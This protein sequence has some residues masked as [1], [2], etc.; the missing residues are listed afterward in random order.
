VAEPAANVAQQ[1]GLNRAILICGWGLAEGML[2]YKCARN[3]SDLLKIPPHGSSRTCS[4]CDDRDL[5]NGVTRDRFHG[6][7][8]R[9]EQVADWNAALA[10][11]GQ[12]EDAG[13]ASLA[14][15]WR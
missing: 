1:S 12:L 15:G 13:L 8:C 11:T 4:E 6:I 2:A 10:I 5:L 9:H 14:R 7:R 3:G